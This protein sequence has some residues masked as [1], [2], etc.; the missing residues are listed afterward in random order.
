MKCRTSA[1]EDFLE[2]GKRCRGYLPLRRQSP[3]KLWIIIIIVVGVIL[4]IIIPILIFCV[5]DYILKSKALKKWD[6]KWK[7]ANPKIVDIR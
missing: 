7:A 3:I 6:H 5:K 2:Y 1:T 4:L